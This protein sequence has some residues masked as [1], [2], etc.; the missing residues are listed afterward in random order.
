M[1]SNA[2]QKNSRSRKY[3]EPTFVVFL[4]DLLFSPEAGDD[5][6]PKCS[7]SQKKY[8]EL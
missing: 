6:F 3:A 1:K 7:L 4:L 5:I 2:K 8:K